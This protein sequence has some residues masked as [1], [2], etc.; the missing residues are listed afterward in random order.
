MHAPVSHTALLGYILR[1][2]CSYHWSGSCNG[3]LSPSFPQRSRGMISG[4]VRNLAAEPLVVREDPMGDMIHIEGVRKIIF[5][6]A[7]SGSIVPECKSL[8]ASRVLLVMD[9]ALSETDIGSRVQKMFQKTKVKAVPYLEVT[10]EPPPTLANAGAELAKHEKIQCVV[11]I[12]GG[13]SIDAAKAIAMLV[14]NEGKVESNA[15]S[16]KSIRSLLGLC[17]TRKVTLLHFSSSSFPPRRSHGHLITSWHK[18]AVPPS[19]GMTIPGTIM[20]GGSIYW[21]ERACFP[22]ATP[23][24]Q[25]QGS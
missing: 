22:R 10:P 2:S 9:R 5:G 23:S 11:G 6:C 21:R 1:V 19:T 24:R 8:G 14:K 25:N 4:I 13:S 17:L 15:P 16:V 3:C 18:R 12:G 7:S 20:K